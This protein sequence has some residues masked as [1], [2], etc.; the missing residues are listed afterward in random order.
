MLAQVGLRPAVVCT[1]TSSAECIES[2]IIPYSQIKTRKGPTSE[3][4]L[5]ENEIL[6][7][8]DSRNILNKI[9]G[10]A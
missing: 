4:Y 7:G 3:Q 6:T 10:R 2:W 5:G 1:Y 9:E 8:L